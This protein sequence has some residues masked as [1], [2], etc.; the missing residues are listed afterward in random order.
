MR[1]LITSR[2]VWLALGA[3][4]VAATV[5]VIV[6]ART[7]RRPIQGGRAVCEA[8]LPVQA[9]SGPGS[10]W[11]PVPILGTPTPE[12]LARYAARPPAFDGGVAT[13]IFGRAEPREPLDE[14]FRR[15]LKRWGIAGF[16]LLVLAVGTQAVE[17]AVYSKE[18]EEAVV[19]EPYGWSPD[20]FH[21]EPCI[22]SSCYDSE[23]GLRVVLDSA[24][25]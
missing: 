23:L 19:V 12:D 4:V 2:G 10:P 24:H 8:S 16:T 25:P 14:G 18:P 21:E 13:A 5:V 6:R 9:E 1:R 22:A 15:R 7:R 3:A 20:D 11:P 17:S